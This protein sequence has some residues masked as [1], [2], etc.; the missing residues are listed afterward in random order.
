[1]EE[2]FL[3][4][5]EKLLVKNGFD[6]E[7]VKNT[8]TGFDINAGENITTKELKDGKAI[9]INFKEGDFEEKTFSIDDVSCFI[10][11]FSKDEINLKDFINF[12]GEQYKILY[13][14]K[15]KAK[16]TTIVYKIAL[17]R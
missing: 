1:M 2:K 5:A 11:A 7:I 4:L 13:L 12:S 14:N 17:G 15:I 3:K 10:L 16:L 6:I 9:F 8:K